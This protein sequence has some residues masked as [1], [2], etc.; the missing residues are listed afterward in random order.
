MII[1]VLNSTYVRYDTSF[2]NFEEEKKKKK[3]KN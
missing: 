1:T 2:E 3:K